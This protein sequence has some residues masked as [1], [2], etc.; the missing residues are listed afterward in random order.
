MRM[1]K[2]FILCVAVAMTL[3]STIGCTSLNMGS[4]PSNEHKLFSVQDPVPADGFIADQDQ[5]RSG[6]VGF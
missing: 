4:G 6:S 2:C 3:S 1:Q 5:D